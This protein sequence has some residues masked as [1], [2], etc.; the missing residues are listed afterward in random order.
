MEM[1]HERSSTMTH[2]E[3]VDLHD[4]YTITP[5]YDNTACS[6][7]INGTS[8]GSYASTLNSTAPADRES[9]CRGFQLHSYQKLD[10]NKLQEILIIFQS[11]S[12][13]LTIEW[14]LLLSKQLALCQLQ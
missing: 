11:D 6:L 3:S 7:E 4:V 14:Y 12:S 8:T 5:I 9:V 13:K 10:D 1:N 2:S